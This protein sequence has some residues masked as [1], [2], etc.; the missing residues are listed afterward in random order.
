MLA[1]SLSTV[2]LISASCSSSCR[3]RA[4]TRKTASS[5]TR[6][7]SAASHSPVPAISPSAFSRSSAIRAVS[8]ALSSSVRSA[9]LSRS[10][11]SAPSR[12]SSATRRMASTRLRWRSSLGLAAGGVVGLICCRFPLF[13][14]S[15]GLVPALPPADL[16]IERQLGRF[17]RSL[18]GPILGAAATRLRIG[19]RQQDRWLTMLDRLGGDDHLLDIGALR[20]V[21]H[22]LQQ[23]LLDDGAQRA[24]TG[25]PVQGAVRGG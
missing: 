16:G 8:R 15:V 14:S 6:S 24:G 1:T 12:A 23:R 2:A 13:G 17:L 21:V 5:R 19:L 9:T 18:G 7:I 4:S 3:R 22:H 11:A 25:L 20:D 10:L